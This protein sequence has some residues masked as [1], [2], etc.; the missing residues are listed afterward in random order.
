M[1]SEFWCSQ[2]NESGGGCKVKCI[3]LADD[4]IIDDIKCAKQ[5][6]S[7]QG[8]DAWGLSEACQLTSKNITKECFGMELDSIVDDS[9]SVLGNTALMIE[10]EPIVPTD[11]SDV[12]YFER[13]SI[14]ETAT[15]KQSMNSIEETNTKIVSNTMIESTERSLIDSSMTPS[16]ENLVTQPTTEFVHKQ[17]ESQQIKDLKNSSNLEGIVEMSESYVKMVKSNQ[18]STSQKNE[19]SSNPDGFTWEKE[20]DES[21]LTEAY[22]TTEMSE[23]KSSSGQSKTYPESFLWEQ[24]VNSTQRTVNTEENSTEIIQ[25]T[26]IDTENSSVQS[27]TYPDILNQDS[28][29][30][31]S[32]I[33]NNVFTLST[34]QDSPAE[35]KQ[36][37][38]YPESSIQEQLIEN[39][40]T[41]K[42]V[43]LEILSERKQTNTYPESSIK[44]LMSQNSVTEIFETTESVQAES[45]TEQKQTK[46]YPESSIQE[47]MSENSVTEN[48]KTTEPVQSKSSIEQKQRSS[49]LSESSV[50][51]STAS[52]MTEQETTLENIVEPSTVRTYVLISRETTSSDYLQLTTTEKKSEDSETNTETTVRSLLNSETTEKQEIFEFIKENSHSPISYVIDQETTLENN[53]EPTTT[54]NYVMISRT[55]TSSDE[56]ETFNTEKSSLETTTKQEA[57]EFVRESSRSPVDLETEQ[58]TI[59]MNNVEPSTIKKYVLIS[60]GSNKNGDVETTFIGKDS[61]DSSSDARNLISENAPTKQDTFEFIEESSRIPK[62]IQKDQNM[63]YEEPRTSNESTDSENL[64]VSSKISETSTEKENESTLTAAISPIKFDVVEDTIKSIK[65][66]D[67]GES[68][69]LKDEKEVTT[70][71]MT[72]QDTTLV[73]TST[74]PSTKLSTEPST[75]S[76]TSKTELTSDNLIPTEST[77]ESESSLILKVLKSSESSKTEGSTSTGTESTTTL[78]TSENLSITESSSTNESSTNTESS[79]SQTT[80]STE[81]PKATKVTNGLIE[82]DFGRLSTKMMQE[83]STT[84]TSEE[85]IS[86]KVIYDETSTSGKATE[87]T[88]ELTTNSTTEK[89]IET[90]TKSIQNENNINNKIQEEIKKSYQTN[91]ENQMKQMNRQQ[92]AT[93]LEMKSDSKMFQPIIYNFFT[94][95]F[96]GNGTNEMPMFDFKQFPFTN[97]IKM[98]NKDQKMEITQHFPMETEDKV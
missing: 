35:Q 14:V 18:E 61:S 92:K 10:N 81:I 47:L 63:N 86:V 3:D 28:N 25:T 31:S 64:T 90:T 22:Q 42:P 7:D 38:T 74:E 33:E 50:N 11:A 98:E 24:N 80:S 65:S 70:V 26:Q 55:T 85:R 2:T 95:N 15:I 5:I 49:P 76:S 29:S 73:L 43:Q 9:T 83:E 93:S 66:L 19:F 27:K 17:L 48:I 21:F 94:F 12:T 91:L 45:S 57:F 67:V 39:S 87:T 6:I 36:T 40:F 32:K 78:F 16:S 51:E 97:T 72:K 89:S 53:V 84:P 52:Y 62:A 20:T 54:R 30:T 37:K 41:D 71:M 44:E 4:D 79:D 69:T 75:E 88:E 46:T 59:P 23:N 34:Q 1:N 68:L 82:S 60:Q 8:F 56:P 77:S 13:D 96:N 58:D